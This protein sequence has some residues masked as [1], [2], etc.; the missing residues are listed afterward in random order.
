MLGLQVLHADER[1]EGNNTEGAIT[2]LIHEYK[3]REYFTLN[4]QQKIMIKFYFSSNL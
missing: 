2:L 3:Q 1:A 4:F